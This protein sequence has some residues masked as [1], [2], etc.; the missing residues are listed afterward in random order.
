MNI[1]NTIFFKGIEE[2]ECK[3]I[4]STINYYKGTYP[5]GKVIFQEGDICNSLGLVLDGDVQIGRVYENG[6]EIVLNNL[7]K[8]EV[9]GEALI[10]SK[11]C[12]YPA[13]IVA[14]TNCEIAFITRKEVLKVCSNN[15]KV[16]ENFMSLLSD[17]VIM[18]NNKIK[19]ISLKTVE[20]K[21]VNYI[22]EKS[23]E[24][25]STIIKLNESK[26]DIAAYIGIPRPSFSRELI[27]LRNEELII[28][29]RKTITILDIDELEEKLFE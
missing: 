25:K 7:S 28:F 23:K 14:K 24:Q 21:V 19:S 3:K 1:R 6:K 13:T 12:L 16:L 22:V 2:E 11:H 4:I 20:Q 17:K 9:F 29:D 15:E 8:G 18:L 26:E 27:K 5:K 10:F